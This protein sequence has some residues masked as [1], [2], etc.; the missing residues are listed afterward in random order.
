MF[1]VVMTMGAIATGSCL[2]CCGFFALLPDPEWEQYESKQ[3]GYKIDLPAPPRENMPVQHEAKDKAKV[4]RTIEGTILTSRGEHYTISYW[5]WLPAQRRVMGDDQLLDEFVTKT[6]ADA[7]GRLANPAKEH[8]VSGFP[9]RD[10]KFRDKK[11]GR[12]VARLVVA[13]DRI[14]LLMVSGRFSEPAREHVKHFFDSFEITDPKRLAFAK[15]RA[16]M[17]KPGAWIK[18]Q[19]RQ[20]QEELRNVRAAAAAVSAAA[21]AALHDDER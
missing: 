3:G 6:V 17:A 16:D 10:F 9:A 2:C 21:V 12:H 11:G 18:I 15:Q 5:D 1:W 13:D 20:R 19:E 14:Y 7:N 8:M 4:N